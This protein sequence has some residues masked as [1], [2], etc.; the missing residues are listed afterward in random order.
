M[1]HIY[2]AKVYQGCIQAKN[3][4]HALSEWS[5]IHRVGQI[6]LRAEESSTAPPEKIPGKRKKRNIQL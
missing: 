1:Y 6:I 5:K 3:P 2:I 4:T